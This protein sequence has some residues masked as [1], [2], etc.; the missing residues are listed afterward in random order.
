MEKI[1]NAVRRYG[2]LVVS[3]GLPLLA[4]A[5]TDQPGPAKAPNGISPP[6]AT[7]INSVQSVLNLVCTVFDWAFYFLIALAVLVPI[8]H[9]RRKSRAGQ[10]C[11]QYIVVCG[12]RRCRSFA[13]K[14]HTAHHRQFL[15]GY[16]YARPDRLLRLTRKPELVY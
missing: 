7:G 5:Q 2:L 10:S 6:S 8:S 3:L 9:G 14:G 12:H 11:E 13:C 4:G 1:S 15:R 16:E